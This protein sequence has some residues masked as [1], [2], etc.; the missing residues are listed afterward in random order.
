MAQVCESQII[1]S[2]LSDPFSNFENNRFIEI[3]NPTGNSIDLTDWTL[4]AIGNNSACNT[5]GLSG[6][7]ESQEALVAGGT[8]ATIMI[9][10][11]SASW[12]WENNISNC[13]FTWNGQARDGAQLINNL[14]EVIDIVLA[15]T[16]A[17][18]LYFADSS[19]TRN[20][21]IC[22][23]SSL[24]TRT[25]WTAT[26]GN[27]S[28]PGSHTAP[29]PPDA[30][31]SSEESITCANRT[32][33][34]RAT[35]GDLYDFGMGFNTIDTFVVAPDAPTTYAI[36]A[37]DSS[38]GCTATASY[39]IDVDEQKPEIE[40]LTNIDYCQGS[41][42]QWSTL[43]VNDLTS[44]NPTIEVWNQSYTTRLS[45]DY[46]TLQSETIHIVAFNSEGNGC[47]DT[48]QINLNYIPLPDIALSARALCGGIATIDITGP[49]NME[50]I[51]VLVSDGVEEYSQILDSNTGVGTMLYEPTASTR[52]LSIIE[53]SVP[54]TSGSCI[55]RGG[56][57]CQR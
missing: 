41:S 47:S 15:G 28:T 8:T 18:P 19:Y 20:I 11:E 24:Y 56:E 4:Q 50:G 34:L 44:S 21:D 57:D 3:Y 17:T 32:V 51:T 49:S 42:I 54:T 55:F 16:T 5:W 12:N 26:T 10:F 39:T 36:I 30:M 53:V 14:G 46:T 37:M 9:D 38:T 7:I 29:I 23:P 2:E 6:V 25:E 22:K 13:N 35:G 48:A 52:D 40:T 31:L 43:T 33:S 45:G 1:I 27:N